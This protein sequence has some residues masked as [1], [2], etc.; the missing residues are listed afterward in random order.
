MDKLFKKIKKQS[1]NDVRQELGRA[2]I[3][4]ALLA[5]VSIALLALGSAQDII[6]DPTLSTVAGTLLGILALISV[7]ISYY[8]TNFK[9]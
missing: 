6:F 9:K 5:V 1:S 3:I 8:L 4:I 2:H 7:T